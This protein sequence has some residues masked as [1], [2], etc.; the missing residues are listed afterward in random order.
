MID[1]LEEAHLDT[2]MGI[3]SAAYAYPWSRRIFLDCLRS[4]YPGW[5]YKADGELVAYAVF[6]QM[7]D[8]AHLLNICVRTESRGQGIA[9]MMMQHLET[10]CRRRALRSILL[11][12]RL[13][14]RVA[15][16]IY[17]DMGFNEIGVRR[18]YYPAKQGRE[19]ALVLA[20]ALV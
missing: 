15:L 6:V 16:K 10:E 14:N 18:K 7:I 9:R 3:E 2:I 5:I 13:S 19:D 4:G 11:E 12:V 20:K 17:S 8:E 1:R